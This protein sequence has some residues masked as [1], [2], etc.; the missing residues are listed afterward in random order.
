MLSFSGLKAVRASAQALVLAGIVGGLV[1]SCES[2]VVNKALPSE[3]AS[4]NSSAVQKDA[5]YLRAEKYVNEQ[6]ALLK[7]QQ[8]LLDPEYVR[9]IDRYSEAVSR[10]VA[11]WLA[12]PS[13]QEQLYS[14]CMER[15]DGETN[16]LWNT[17]DNRVGFSRQIAATAQNV[18]KSSEPSQM[19]GSVAE[20]QKSLAYLQQQ[21]HAPM[22]LYWAFAQNWDKKTTPL[23]A[24]I[25]AGRQKSDIGK[26]LTGFDAEG[27]RYEITEAMAK[28]RP[29]V[30]FTINER[31]TAKGELKTNMITPQNQA[32]VLRDKG[33]SRVQ[34]GNR[35]I[36]I[37]SM[38][39]STNT[40]LYDE[41]G[42][43]SYEIFYDVDH[44]VIG[45]W[46]PYYTTRPSGPPYNV[47]SQRVIPQ[48][49]GFWGQYPLGQTITLHSSNN[50]LS[51]YS[52]AINGYL[53][54]IFRWWEDD[55][56]FSPDGNENDYIF[57]DNLGWHGT[58]TNAGFNQSQTSTY[59]GAVEINYSVY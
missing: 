49:D 35:Y 48:G 28:Q 59:P 7:K 37:N 11:A 20:V 1:V 17:F 33:A 30:V 4:A 18:K 52:S 22:H 26:P 46:G 27:N 39:L 9:S 13:A 45:S 6:L 23:V 41:W 16:V 36:N 53:G 3:E 14:A 29:V 34:N 42:N 54:V 50:H 57:D 12:S 5:S 38:K 2:G 47:Q 8:K 31:T 21:A 19:L 55:T 43:G 40:S 15:F 25:S 10:T 24:Y 44:E 56:L 58:F 51:E 32:N